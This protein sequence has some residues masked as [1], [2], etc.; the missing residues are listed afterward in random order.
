[1]ARY[2]IVASNSTRPKLL[3]VPSLKYSPLITPTLLQAANMPLDLIQSQTLFLLAKREI[4]QQSRRIIRL[5]K[6]PLS[7][8][9]LLIVCFIYTP[10][11]MLV[12]KI[13]I[14]MAPLKKGDR[15]FLIYSPAL[16]RR[17]GRDRCGQS[18]QDKKVRGGV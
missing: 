11:Y 18:E 17:Q 2:F 14:D 13:K 16:R 4:H 1:M 6:M 7:Y 9:I 15:S 5:T 10:L 12:S 3:H 8:F